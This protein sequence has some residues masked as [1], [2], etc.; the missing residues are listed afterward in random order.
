MERALSVL[1]DPAGKALSLEPG[2]CTCRA[3]TNSII[4]C[5]LRARKSLPLRKPPQCPTGPHPRHCSL[6]Q[7]HSSIFFLLTLWPWNESQPLLGPYSYFMLSP[8]YTF[9]SPKLLELTNCCS[10]PRNETTKWSL[11]SF[12][13]PGSGTAC[14][15]STDAALTKAKNFLYEDFCDDFG[16]YPHIF[17]FSYCQNCA[18]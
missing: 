13:P 5:P 1:G 3:I 2:T 18:E 14:V 9:I 8:W 17:F 16:F 7:C 6:I 15:I 10:C 12:P 4:T 11:P